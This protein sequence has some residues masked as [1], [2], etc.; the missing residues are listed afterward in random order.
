MYGIL[1]LLSVIDG[2]NTSGA[3]SQLQKLRTLH[4]GADNG[5]N[6]ELQ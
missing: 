3:S 6:N 2:G 1:L 4:P 5:G